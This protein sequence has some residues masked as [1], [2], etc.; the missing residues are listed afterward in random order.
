V[1]NAPERDTPNHE[2][3]RERAEGRKPDDLAR[4]PAEDELETDATIPDPEDAFLERDD[5][6][7]SEA[8][9]DE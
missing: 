9:R 1:K 6:H 7:Y 5:T 4:D 8:D 2:T 3:A